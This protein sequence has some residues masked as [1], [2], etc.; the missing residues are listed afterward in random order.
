MDAEVGR[1]KDNDAQL[2]IRREQELRATGNA[3]VDAIRAKLL[4]LEIAG[5]KPVLDCVVFFND[6]DLPNG[7][8]LPGHSIEPLI[9]D[10]LSQSTDNDVLA[11]VIWNS[12]GGGIQTHGGTT[13]TATD[14]LGDPQ[15]MKFSR[16]T[17]KEF[18][19]ELT[20]TLTD[21]GQLASQYTDAVKAACLLKHAEK[22]EM[23]KPIR[24]SDYLVAAKAIPGIDDCSVRL[25][26]LA[27]AF[28]VPGVN[29]TL[30]AREKSTLQTSGITVL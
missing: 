22:A 3:A 28:T 30:L 17:I 24:A 26:F 11:Q 29:L 15:V 8:G 6:D 25:A 23:G 18:K 19:A 16:P 13:G 14:A 9:D 20:L 1:N 4:D 2:R 21:S 10:G 27:D 5:E 7:N 12:K